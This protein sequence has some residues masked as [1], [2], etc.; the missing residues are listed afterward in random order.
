MNARAAMMLSLFA[1][2][3]SVSVGDPITPVSADSVCGPG[4]HQ[5]GQE[6]PE[7]QGGTTIIHPICEPDQQIVPAHPVTMRAQ[8]RAECVRDAGEQ[9]KEDLSVCRGPIATCLATE[10]VTDKAA[11]CV[12]DGLAAAV[13]LAATRAPG[14][15]RLAIAAAA[16][17]VEHALRSCGVSSK[18]IAKAC[19]PTAGTCEEGPLKAH[20]AAVKRCR[21]N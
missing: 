4:Y 7:V 10:G 21:A 17:Q 1:T 20:K 12:E 19:A 2:C 5:N 15:G 14:I 8:T 13:T 18:E 6:P 11:D 16:L 9:L 3:V